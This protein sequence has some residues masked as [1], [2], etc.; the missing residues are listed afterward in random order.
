ML[1]VEK[2]AGEAAALREKHAAL[3]QE[4]DAAA[5]QA[6]RAARVRLWLKLV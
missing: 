5:A 2:G 3:R 4:R 6:A 1:Q